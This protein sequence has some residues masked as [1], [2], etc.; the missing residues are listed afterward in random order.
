M[1]NKWVD[2]GSGKQ[3][4]IKVVWRAARFI[5]NKLFK[6]PGLL[7]AKN[8]VAATVADMDGRAAVDGMVALLTELNLTQCPIN[9][10]GHSQGT[11]V[12][13]AALAE[14]NFQV[15]NVVMMNSPHHL[16]ENLMDIT[17]AKQRIVGNFSHFWSKHDEA[18]IWVNQRPIV[19]W[20]TGFVGTL[21]K[22]V[23]AL[24]KVFG[25]GKYLPKKGLVNEEIHNVAGALTQTEVSG[26]HGDYHSFHPAYGFG[27][28]LA[29]NIHEVDN[30][31][32]RNRLQNFINNK[33]PAN[34]PVQVTLMNTPTG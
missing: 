16:D 33:F 5:S 26:G 34:G 8:S 25:E 13:M 19:P 32:L 1:Y 15:N 7:D 22:L 24:S 27:D 12:T 6:Q 11:M 17:N 20:P 14:I 31:Q 29:S 9:I 28:L 2:T 4:G 30:G 23:A 21:A 18:V 10:V 3:L